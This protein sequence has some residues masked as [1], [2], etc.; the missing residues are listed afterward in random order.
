M[1]VRLALSRIKTG[2]DLM[3]EGLSLTLFILTQGWERGRVL[4]KIT[5]KKKQGK[6]G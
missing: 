5:S 6:S 4:K 1:G 3:P 2:N